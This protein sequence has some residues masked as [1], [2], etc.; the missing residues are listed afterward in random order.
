MLTLTVTWGK[1]SC[2]THFHIQKNSR[3]NIKF[4]TISSFGA[5]LTWVYT[6]LVF[7]YPTNLTTPLPTRFCSQPEVFPKV[8]EEFQIGI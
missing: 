2:E 1:K 8:H 7:S 5:N 4:Q 3:T 6:K